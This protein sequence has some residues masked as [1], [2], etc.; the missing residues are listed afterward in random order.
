MSG[1]HESAQIQNLYVKA[2]QKFWKEICSRPKNTNPAWDNDGSKDSIFNGAINDN[3]FYLSFRRHGTSNRMCNVPSGKSLFIPAASVVATGFERPK[4][5]PEQ[6]AAL[7]VGDQNLNILSGG[8]YLFLDGVPVLNLNHYNV[9]STKPFDVEFPEDAI[10][11]GP[12]IT[13]EP[14]K[15]VAAGRYVIAEPPS[16][17]LHHVS[18]GSTIQCPENVDCIEEYFHEE[19]KYELNVLPAT[20]K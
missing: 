3:F 11:P 7:A 4:D 15:A 12:G 10:F 16:I 20:S 9:L 1:P 17:G 18:F 14:V 6:L 19:V 5:T 2:V 8:P 13:G